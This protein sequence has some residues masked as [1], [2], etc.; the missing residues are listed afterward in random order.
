MVFFCVFTEN[1]G[2]CGLTGSHN[3]PMTWASLFPFSYKKTETQ[4]HLRNLVLEEG[5]QD[6]SSISAFLFPA[7]KVDS[8]SGLPFH[9]L[10][11]GWAGAFQSQPMPSCW[12]KGTS[13]C[14]PCYTSTI[15]SVTLNHKRLSPVSGLRWDMYVCLLRDTS[16]SH[17]ELD[18][19][20]GWKGHRREEL[21]QVGC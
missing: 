14:S 18:P 7:L 5:Q 11:A 4:M 17:S 13:L 16:C 8:P 20:N 9:S 3:Y 15:F 12:E 6:T 19:D 2:I 1:Y 21:G 10:W